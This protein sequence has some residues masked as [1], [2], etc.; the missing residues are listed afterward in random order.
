[1]ATAPL[2]R[3]RRGGRWA[4]FRALPY[5]FVWIATGKARVLA[6]LPSEPEPEMDPRSSLDESISTRSQVP[7]YED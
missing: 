2:L 5:A 6:A 1:M 3:P 7:P 4:Y